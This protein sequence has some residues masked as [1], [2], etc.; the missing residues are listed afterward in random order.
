MAVGYVNEHDPHAVQRWLAGLVHRLGVSVIVTDDLASYRMVAERLQL[1]HQ[2]CQFHVWR[3]VG[4][5]LKELKETV[6]KEWIWVMEEVEELMEFLPPEG[7]K[8]LYA[9]WKKST[10]K[11]WWT[12]S[13]AKL[14]HVPIGTPDPPDQQCHRTSHWA[15]EDASQ[16]RARLQILARHANRIAFGCYTLGLAQA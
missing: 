8:R 11:R 15:H 5:A 1:G 3:W 4:K 16:N 14:L 10:W 12:L 13:W 2:V 6:P 9:L 7:D